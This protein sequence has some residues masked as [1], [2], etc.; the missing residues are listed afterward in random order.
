M[1]KVIKTIPVGPLEANCYVYYDDTK[2]A[3]V[4]D[5]G[6]DPAE[7]K[8]EVEALGLNVKYVVNT[9]GHFDHVGA[10]REIK[11]AFEAE[12]AIHEADS[13]LL[14]DAHDH[15]V[16]FGESISSQPAPDL[17]LTD[18]TELRV[19]KAA[20]DVI[21]TPGHT[22]GG[23]C[24]YEKNEKILFTGD[25]L[26][27][28]SVG[29]TDLEGGSHQELMKSIKEKL[30]PLGDDVKVYPGHGPETTIG[31]EKEINPFLAEAMRT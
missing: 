12:L 26:F 7:I 6:G 2:E 24:L 8:R 5:P 21:H 14:A 4:I 27:A 15:A 13:T 22:P 3:L 29:R 9:H 18:G 30:V 16:I 23:I 31:T 28:G 10:V 20:F 19:G 11:E 25:T 17:L 1:N